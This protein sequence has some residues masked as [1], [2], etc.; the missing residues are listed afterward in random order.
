[1]AKRKYKLHTVAAFASPVVVLLVALAWYLHRLA[2]PVLEPAGQ[3]GQKER[4]LII[5]A[6]LLAVLVVVPVYMMTIVIAVKYKESNHTS[7]TK[8]QPDFDHSIL[9]EGIWWGV[10]IAIITA[11]SVLAWQSSYSLNP[12]RPIAST[13]TPLTIQ[14]IALD[15]KWLFIY[16]EQHIAT[17]NVAHIPVN[18]PIAFNL[19]SDTVMNSFWVPGLGGQIYVMP[20]MHTQLNELATKPTTFFGS[21]ANIAG[22]GFARMDFTIT[23]T[24]SQDFNSW[25][26]QVRRSPNALNSAS[27]AQLARPSDDVKPLYYSHAASNLFEDVIMS[28]LV[29]K[30]KPSILPHVT[31]KAGVQ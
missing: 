8:Y 22:S 3:I 7:K 10:P 24:S 6:S 29:P 16:P 28:Y 17:V 14:V 23:S 13:Q 27:Y 5:Y 12:S 11:L 30:G 19:T 31:Y 1:M 21:P 20:G 26:Q 18:T 9:F 4:Q 15:W 2:I 25:V